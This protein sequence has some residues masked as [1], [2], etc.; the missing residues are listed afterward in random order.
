MCTL[1]KEKKKSWFSLSANLFKIIYKNK[2]FTECKIPRAWTTIIHLQ[3]ITHM[4]FPPRSYSALGSIQEFLTNS[5][6]YLRTIQ[7]FTD[8]TEITNVWSQ[9]HNLLEC[10][11]WH[12]V[13]AVV[14]I[15]SQEVAHSFPACL[16]YGW[17][18]KVVQLSIAGL[19]LVYSAAVF[20]CS[21]IQHWSTWP[22]KFL[23][24]HLNCLKL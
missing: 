18:K 23:L 2:M 22:C 14:F 10:I 16:W 24:V 3:M 8:A 15:F 6:K 11:S 5:Q 9:Q 1:H 20:Q 17:Y 21:V 7:L 12:R 13:E 4:Q 19:C